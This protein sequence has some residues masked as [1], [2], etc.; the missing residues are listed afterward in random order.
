MI[1]LYAQLS[2]NDKT[3]PA[4]WTLPKLIEQDIPTDLKGQLQPSM[5]EQGRG[6]AE[7]EYQRDWV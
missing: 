1:E 4:K 6:C 3:A 5:K 7:S 2:R